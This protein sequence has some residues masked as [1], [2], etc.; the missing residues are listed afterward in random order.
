M[1]FQGETT[2]NLIPERPTAACADLLSRSR[3]SSTDSNDKDVIDGLGCSVLFA[4]IKYLLLTIV[5]V[6][7]YSR[8]S[9]VPQTTL[10]ECESG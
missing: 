10:T 6:P 8:H 9:W 1:E 3:G 4:A 2:E 5:E 7:F